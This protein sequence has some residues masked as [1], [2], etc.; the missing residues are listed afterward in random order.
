[1]ISLVRLLSQADMAGY[2]VSLSDR[3]VAPMCVSEYNNRQ[4]GQDVSES[5][6]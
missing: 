2:V 4:E 5:S 3:S 6:Q 1:M